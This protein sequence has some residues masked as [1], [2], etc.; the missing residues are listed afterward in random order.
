MHE[1]TKIAAALADTKRM[2]AVVALSQ[3]DLTA[4]ELA[5]IMGIQASATSY[6]LKVLV[7]AGVVSVHRSDF[8]SRESYYRVQPLV[9][10]TYVRSLWAHCHAAIKVTTAEVRLL[11]VCRANS[12]RSQMAEAFVRSLGLPAVV[13][14]SAGVH[15][16]HIHPLTEVVMDEV[17]ISL[18]AQ[19]AKT[20]ADVDFAPTHVIS[21]C[22]YARKAV[23]SRWPTATYIHWSI[24]DP[25][26][27]GTVHDFRRARDEIRQRVTNSFVHTPEVTL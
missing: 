2:A 25:A 3:T 10:A 1:L 22:D 4:H 7:D 16:S 18:G 14:Q 19:S 27:I 21:V 13:V 15:V 8:D 9:I 6:Q 11:F 12:A 26:K 5:D 24:D 20:I 17:G 23:E